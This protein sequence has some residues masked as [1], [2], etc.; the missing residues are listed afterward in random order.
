MT[1]LLMFANITRL[2]IMKIA[3]NNLIRELSTK[4]GEENQRIDSLASTFAYFL[5]WY[6]SNDY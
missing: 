4:L 6:V 5:A 3:N 1:G 2:E